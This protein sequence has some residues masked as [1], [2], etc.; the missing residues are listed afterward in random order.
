MGSEDVDVQCQTQSASASVPCESAASYGIATVPFVASVSVAPNRSR[1]GTPV[2][3]NAVMLA[4]SA[5]SH[6]PPQN[7]AVQP[8]VAASPLPHVQVIQQPLQNQYLQHLYAPQQQHMFLP[9]NLTLQ[10]TIQSIGAT[11]AGISL[12]LQGK[13]MENKAATPTI[14]SAAPMQTVGSFGTQNLIPASSQMAAT[15]KACVP[16]QMLAASSK[17]TVIQGQ[18]GFIPVTSSNQ[19]VVIGQLGVLSNPQTV[20]P[21]Q[22]KAITDGQKGKS[23]LISQPATLHPKSPIL[24]SPSA[25]CAGQMIATSQLKQI[26]AASHILTTQAPTMITNQ[27]QL[28]GSLQALGVPPGITWAAPGSLHSSALF[29][30]NP[31]FI[32]SQQ[33]DMFIQSPPP[34]ATIHA[35]PVAPQI[36]Q[37]PQQQQQQQQTHQVQQQQAQ[38]QVQQQVQQTQQ[39]QSVQ[40]QQAQQ[41]V[42]Q[43]VQQQQPIQQ[44]VSQQHVQPQT[45][46]IILPAPSTPAPSSYKSKPPIRPGSSVATQTIVSTSAATST[47]TAISKSQ[48]KP[49]SRFLHCRT[50]S[51]PTS[52]SHSQTATTQTQTQPPPSQ[53]ADAANQTKPTSEPKLASIYNKILESNTDVCIDN[54]SEK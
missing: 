15:A 52:S 6:T 39:Q 32:R 44:Q 50:V 8:S 35:V 18:S 23:Y 1:T 11:P 43:Q 12:Q 46:P 53:K 38:Q 19:T 42:Q 26:P 34:Q 13:G 10:P 25:S 14:I 31:I 30:Q 36:Q 27:A 40:Q 9:G 17:S 29:G 47:S 4:Q 20:L 33:S 49:R 51:I 3:A 45:Q 48:S 21:H 22:A 54:S 37:Q 24:P 28:L 2:S 7:V 16:G 41:Q 5:A